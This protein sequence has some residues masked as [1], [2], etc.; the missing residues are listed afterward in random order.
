MRPRARQAGTDAC[1]EDLKR[2]LEEIEQAEARLEDGPTASS[3]VSRQSDS[4]GRLEAIPWADRTSRRNRAAPARAASRRR[5]GRR[6][7]TSR[8]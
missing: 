5:Y 1:V 6:A 8:L 7:E 3:V 2:T 4:D